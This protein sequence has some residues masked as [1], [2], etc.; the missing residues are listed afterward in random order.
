MEWKGPP[1]EKFVEAEEDLHIF[2]LVGAV[3]LHAARP[4]AQEPATPRGSHQHQP[5]H[6]K[7]PRFRAETTFAPPQQPPAHLASS[8]YDEFG[9]TGRDGGGWGTVTGRET[10]SAAGHEERRS[11]A[12]PRAFAMNTDM[13]S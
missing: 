1:V 5:G 9:G 2:G 3:N 7:A 12:I 11:A 6:A 13:A 4:A 8:R 10:P